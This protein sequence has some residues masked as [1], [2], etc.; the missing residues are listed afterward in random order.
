MHPQIC[1]IGPYVIYS[2]GLMLVIAFSVATALACRQAKKSGINPDIIFNLNFIVFI[3]GILGA[4]IFYV[5][6]HLDYYLR[7]LPEIIMLN[8]GGLSW[9]GGLILGVFSGTLYLRQKKIKAY[10]IMDLVMPFVALAQAIGRLGC[11]L[12]GCCY[13][14]ESIHGIYFPGHQAT[15]IPVQLYSALI[16]FIIFIILR[17]LQSRPHKEGQIFFT[18]L[19]LYGAKRFFIEF[20]RQDNPSILF[21]LTLFQLLSVFIFLLATVKL[22]LIKTK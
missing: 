18:Y 6:G 9:F 5:A 7:N 1:R 10:R 16:L 3:F 21:G 20:W 13:G 4:R 12:N 19:L 15:L 14:R 17:F 8:K 2:Y 22:F 11:F